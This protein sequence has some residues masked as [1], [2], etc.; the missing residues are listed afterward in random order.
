L[1]LRKAQNGKE[2][3]ESTKYSTLQ[4]VGAGLAIAAIIVY[5][6]AKFLM[7]KTPKKIL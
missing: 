5:T 2:E 1:T 7:K 3:D 6:G 4:K